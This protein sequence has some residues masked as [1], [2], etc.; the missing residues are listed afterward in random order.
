MYSV[1][2]VR[3]FYWQVVKSSELK[4][5]GINQSGEAIDIPAKRGDIISSDNYPF[6]TTRVSYLLYANPKFI[7]NNSLKYANEISPLLNLD[8]EKVADL[9]SKDLYWV[10]LADNLDQNQKSAIEKLNVPGLG[11]QENDLRFYPEASMAAHLI[12]FLGRDKNGSGKGY[13]GLEGYY[14]DQLSGR[15]GKQYLIHDALG[16]PVLNDLREEKK[17][18]GR[19]LV[20]NIDRTVQFI[21]EKKLKEGIEK[22][23]AEGG[24]AIIMD[25]QSG[26]ILAM[27]SFPRFNPQKYYEFDYDTYRNPV[28]ANLY[29]PGSTFKVLV[30]SAAI[31]LRVLKPD[32]KCNICSG[33]VTI[34]DYTV[35][36]WNGKYYPDSTM[37]EVIQ[38]SDNTG[39][40]YVG[41]KLGLDNLTTY[42]K[43][44]GI[45]QETQIDLEGEESSRIRDKKDW[46][47]IDLATASF[48]QGISV[49]PMQLLTAVSSIANGGNLIKPFVVSQIIT[50]DGKKIDIK[51]QIT[52]RVISEI[53]AKIVT[54]MMVNAVENGEAKWTKL[55]NYKVAGKT[56]TAQIP[57]Q[58]HYDPKETIAS[59][60][61]FFPADNPKVSMLVLVHKPKTSIYG[62]ETAAPIFFSIARDLVNYYS[63]PPTN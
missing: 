59:F 16:N 50:E 13:F 58:G 8:K 30:M 38:H 41:K 12:G 7:K 45:G 55:D 52:R 5:M 2:V 37:A 22:Y 9:L 51:P 33:P 4:Q 43:S 1:V 35:K 28:I 3:L 44:F 27:A 53:T 25:P 57:I 34:G 56:G 21:A 42:I 24:S 23:E 63:I 62:A 14:N 61:G 48:G 19:S 17:I 11:F 15:A 31:D 36:T 54:Q 39:M 46:Y 40:V 18:D 60:V 6:A 32:T 29:E 20:L 26:R 10:K 47:P 49:N